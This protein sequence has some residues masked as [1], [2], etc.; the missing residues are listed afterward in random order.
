MWSMRK[1]RYICCAINVEHAEHAQHLL[2]HRDVEHVK[3]VVRQLDPSASGPA[4]QARFMQNNSALKLH[5][6][7][8]GT[9]LRAHA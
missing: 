6:A 5:A 4:M 8:S 2:R 3:H 1:K 7:I 9:V